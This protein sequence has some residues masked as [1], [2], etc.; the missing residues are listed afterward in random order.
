FFS[1]ADHFV[2]CCFESH[3]LAGENSRSSS[4][5]YEFLPG[6]GCKEVS[7]PLIASESTIAGIRA[8]HCLHGWKNLPRSNVTAS[9][10][11]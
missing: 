1:S 11:A 7:T 2:A 6:D 9:F 4:D 3:L 8:S 10:H 5:Q